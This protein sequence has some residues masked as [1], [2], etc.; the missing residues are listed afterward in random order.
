M[1]V[2]HRYATPA[3]LLLALGLLS[4]CEGVDPAQLGIV[5]DQV[6][7]LRVEVPTFDA[8]PPEGIRLWRR[9]E[10]SG[11]FE[12]ISEI[13]LSSPVVE[14]EQEY[15]EYTLLDPAGQPIEIRLSSM[16]ERNG[17]GARLTLWLIRF[18]PSGEFKA[19]LYN[20]AGESPL[21]NEVVV[22]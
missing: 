11:Q 5:A 18:A 20:Q 14:Q 15:V 19:S 12:P 7:V 21:S 3:V 1:R 17:D 9:A 10:D 22:L 16:L 6:A 13:R 4:G 2:R 8:S